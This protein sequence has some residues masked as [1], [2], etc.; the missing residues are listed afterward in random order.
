M[1]TRRIAEAFPPG[2]FVKEELEARGWTQDDLA[3]ILGRQRSVVSAIVNGRRVLSPE[4]AQDLGDAF[5]T[6]P[7]FWMNLETAY[8]LH[9]KARADETV[10]RRARLFEMAPVKEMIKRNWI[11]PSKDVDVLEKRVLSFFEISSFDEEPKMFTHAAKKS[12]SYKTVTPAQMAWLY[13]AKKLARGVHASKFSQ[14]SLSET[15]KNLKR[16]M[17]NPEDV[18][19]VPRVLADGGVRFL[20]VE[21][22]PQTRIDGACFW[23]DEFSPVIAISLRYDRLDY[24]WY[25]TGHE[26]G[27]LKHLDGLKDNP[28]LDLDLIGDQAIPFDEKPEIEKRADLFAESFLVEKGQI[29]NFILRVRPLYSKKKI[30]AFAIRIGVHPAIVLGQLQHRKEVAYSHSREMLV[31]VRDFVASAAL[32]DGWGQT[33]PALM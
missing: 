23:L 5:G 25:V 16:L 10:S 17:A 8:R 29:E 3:E 7:Q 31:R 11:G 4:I 33:L 22:L 1:D 2:E 15:L 12:T 14:G 19:H 18:R 6:H 24:F 20:V 13:R 9:T 32:T 26:C 27:H 21:S 28:P 30:A